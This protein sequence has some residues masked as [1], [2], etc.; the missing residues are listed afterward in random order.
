MCQYTYKNKLNNTDSS[1]P[2]CPWES[3][4]TPFPYIS[5]SLSTINSWARTQRCGHCSKFFSVALQ[6]PHAV[7]DPYP[8]PKHSGKRSYSGFSKGAGGPRSR[9]REPICNRI[10][11]ISEHM[12]QF[13]AIRK[14][15]KAQRKRR[16]CVLPHEISLY[17]PQAR[18]DTYKSYQETKGIS[19]ERFCGR[20]W[21]AV[22]HPLPQNGNS[23]VAGRL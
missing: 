16:V 6:S 5:T 18:D 4:I 3:L 10:Q 22:G 20:V 17:A 1:Q 2:F 19:D 21:N 15:E 9:Y 23:V 8:L 14:L 11:N 12:N 13:K 7:N